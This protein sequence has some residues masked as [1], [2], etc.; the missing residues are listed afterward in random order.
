MINAVGRCLAVGFLALASS[1]VQARTPEIE[2]KYQASLARLKALD[3]KEKSRAVRDRGENPG[4]ELR[5][6]HAET[7][8]YRP[9]DDP[10]EKMVL[11]R[12]S[13]STQAMLPVA[14][15]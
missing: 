14:L 1:A 5:L 9:Y 2:A 11:T 4:R 10:A 7:S 15:N 12:R 8:A 3:T 13:V 6:L